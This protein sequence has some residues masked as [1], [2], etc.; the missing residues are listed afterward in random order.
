MSNY[1]IREISERFQL[2]ASTLRYYEDQGLL[3]PVQRTANQQRSYS[4]AHIDRLSSI[5]CFKRS[6][7]SIA[8][9]KQ[10]YEYEKDL[11]HQID[12][13][14]SLVSS[15]ELALQTEIK[16]LQEDLRHIQQKV[17]FY[18]GIKKASEANLPWPSFDDFADP[19]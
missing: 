13:I 9:M 4:Q 1:T 10:F 6:G 15:K 7:F 5:A 17:R 12:A 8:E 16:K 18:S 2:P 19:D 3:P 11:P 14:L